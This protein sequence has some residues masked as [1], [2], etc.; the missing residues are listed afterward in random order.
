MPWIHH[1]DP[2][3][4]AVEVLSV[5]PKAFHAVKNLTQ[6]LIFGASALTETQEEAI[7]TVVSVVNRCRY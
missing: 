2:Y 3:P 6:A 4:T 7:A 1:D 5:N